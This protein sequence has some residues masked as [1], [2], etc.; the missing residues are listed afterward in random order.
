MCTLPSVYCAWQAPMF[1]TSLVVGTVFWALGRALIGGADG[2]AEFSKYAVGLQWFSFILLVPSITTRV[3]FP[4]IVRATVQDSENR[5]QLILTNA[6]TNF[7]VAATIGVA[8]L[9]GGDTLLALYGNDEV[10]DVNVF[11]LFVLAA[12]VASPMNGLSNAI[13]ARDPGPRRWLLLQVGWALVALFQCKVPHGRLRR[14]GGRLCLPDW[15]SLPLA[16]QPGD[17]SPD[18]AFVNGAGP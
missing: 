7:L 10:T 15:I 17:A 13:I 14:G 11:R 18:E 1:V 5:R 2:A 9:L 3:F 12:I 16:G 4:R 6:G 8:A